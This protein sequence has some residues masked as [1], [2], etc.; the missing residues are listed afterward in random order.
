MNDTKMEL[1]TMWEEL[2]RQKDKWIGG[3]MTDFG[4]SS[5]RARG[6]VPEGGI[7]TEITDIQITEN[8]LTFV[9]KDFS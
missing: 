1:R 5:D 2:V 7:E 8:Q 9:G 4:Y 3:V 6:D